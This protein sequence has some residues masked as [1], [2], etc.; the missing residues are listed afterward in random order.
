MKYSFFI[1]LLSFGFLNAAESPATLLSASSSASTFFGPNP[2]LNIGTL[3]IEE[4]DKHEKDA[5]RI[6]DFLKPK[7]LKEKELAEPLLQNLTPRL[8]ARKKEDLQYL[9]RLQNLIDLHSIQF[10]VITFEKERRSRCGMNSPE[11][12]ERLELLKEVHIKKYERPLSTAT[13]CLLE[14][15]KRK[16]DQKRSVSCPTGGIQ[17]KSFTLAGAAAPLVQTSPTPPVTPVCN[18]N[19][20]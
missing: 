4:L 15:S 12:A 2:L 5:C 9:N 7:L 13:M 18:T 8:L 20:K 16:S 10:E 14:A 11:R 17:M 19:S 6:I 1:L 3:T